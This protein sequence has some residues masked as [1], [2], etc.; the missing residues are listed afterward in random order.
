MARKSVTRSFGNGSGIL[1]DDRL[2]FVIIYYILQPF[3]INNVN[4]AKQGV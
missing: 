2:T 1:T 3:I 4:L